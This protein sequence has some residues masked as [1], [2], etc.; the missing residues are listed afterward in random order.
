MNHSI[1]HKPI[2]FLQ[3]VVLA[4]F[5]LPGGASAEGLSDRMAWVGLNLFPTFL[6]ADAHIDEK[7]DDD[8]G[9]HLLLVHRGRVDLAEE[10]SRQLGQVG[11]IRGI[12]IRVSEV[13]IGELKD[14]GDDMPAGIFLVERMGDDLQTVIRFG[15]DRHAIVFSPFTGDVEAGISSGMVVSDRILPYVNTEAMRRSDIHMKSFFLRVAELYGE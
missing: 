15:Q 8:G 6:A 5:L 14:M 1:L 2:L 13:N 11:T 12:P 10:L 3:A 9:L 7:K 4:L